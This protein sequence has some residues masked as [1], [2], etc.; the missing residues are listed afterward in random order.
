MCVRAVS[1][2]DEAQFVIWTKGQA[3]PRWGSTTQGG[4]AHIPAGAPATG[5]GGWFAGHLTPGTSMTYR[6][7]SVDGAVPVGLP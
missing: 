5:R 1:A 3:R 6:D 2:A 4:E 7:L